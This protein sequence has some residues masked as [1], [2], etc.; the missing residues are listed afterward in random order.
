MD[1]NNAWLLLWTVV[2]STDIISSVTVDCSDLSWIQERSIIS[3][4][5]FALYIFAE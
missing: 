5:K 1:L 2:V 3:K 4:T